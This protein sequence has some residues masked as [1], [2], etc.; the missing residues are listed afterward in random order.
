MTTASKLSDYFRE[1][2]NISVNEPLQIERIP[3]QELIVPNRI[4]LIAK[5]KYIEY[6]DKGYNSTFARDLYKHHI[7]A[8][9]LGTYREPGNRNKDSFEKYVETFDNLIESIK[10]NGFDDTISVIP[11]GDKN[12]ILDGAHRTAIAAYLDKQVYIARFNNIFADYGT[13]FFKDRLLQENYLD[14]MVSEYCRLKKNVFFACVWPKAKGN[15]SICE[16]ERLISEMC[17]IVYKKELTVTYDGLRHFM[18]QIY[19]S[20]EWV[21]TIDNRFAGVNNK[22]DAC[23]DDNGTL[24]A[25]VLEASD[26]QEILELKK[27]IRAIYGIGNHSVHISDNQFETQQMCR[28]LLNENSIHLLNN[29]EPHLYKSFYTRINVFKNKVIN[30]NMS[31]DDFVVDSSGVMGLYGLREPNDLDFLT[32]SK[33]AE[34]AEDATARN[35]NA[36]AIYYD[37]K[38]DDLILN[39][40]NYLVYND[41][42][43][44]TL[45]VLKKFKL[46]R[47]EAKDMMDVQLIDGLF[48]NKPW[49]KCTSIKVLNWCTRRKRNMKQRFK[50]MIRDTLI[51]LGLHDYVKSV[52][53]TKVK[54]R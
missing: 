46:N 4:D 11:V 45:H 52:Y 20:Q 21:G 30:N 53:H 36:Y 7:E 37:N 15:E 9:S 22:A 48:G 49:I 43:F 33:R 17:T 14:Y 42:K 10:Q 28:I 12:T 34:V 18:S 1:K 41:V 16:M 38:I 51:R 39:P 2:N 50:M 32:I 31:L 3:A 24:R 29:G 40:S 54:K 26:L 35:H 44:I 47:K 25:Y 19:S 27:R 13:N 5:M 23:Y 8:F 6:K